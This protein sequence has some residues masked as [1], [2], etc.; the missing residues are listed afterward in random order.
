[1]LI[2]FH[3]LLLKMGF[4]N[5]SMNIAIFNAQDENDDGTINESG[6]RKKNTLIE[7]YLHFAKNKLKYF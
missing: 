3:Q 1:M 7:H 6:K 2:K 5:R 4:T